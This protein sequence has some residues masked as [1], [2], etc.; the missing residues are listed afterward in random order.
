MN[1]PSAANANIVCSPGQHLLDTIRTIRAEVGDGLN[2]DEFTR[3]LQSMELPTEAGFAFLSYC[4]WFVTLSVPL[5]PLANWYPEKG[6]LMPAKE[7]IA[8]TIAEKYRLSLCE[9]P[10][11]HSPWFGSPNP[12]HH[13]QL[14]FQQE[15]V[16]VIHP[17]YLKIRLFVATSPTQSARISHKPLLLGPDLL[18]DLSKLYH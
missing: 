18:Q 1:Y 2:D 15:P 5:Q 16:L 13:L 10:D 14:S 3:L 11:M 9:P 12:H 4:D 17:Q 6:W 8:R 7:R